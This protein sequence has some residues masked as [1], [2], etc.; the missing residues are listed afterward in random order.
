MLRLLLRDVRGRLGV[1]V[2]RAV[3]P[4][5]PGGACRTRRAWPARG[6]G[7]PRDE[8]RLITGRRAPRGRRR[9][10][11]RAVVPLRVRGVLRGGVGL[12][13]RRGPSRTR[14]AA[15]WSDDA[16]GLCCLG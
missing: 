16:T 10:G 11:L 7:E 15:T 6:G 2:V 4:A 3:M 13:A 5:A 8:L 1:R 12:S 9:R 14:T